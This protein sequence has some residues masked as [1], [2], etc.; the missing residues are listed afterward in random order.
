MNASL[1]RVIVFFAVIAA[2]LVVL[3]VLA[4]RSVRHAELGSD[5]VNRT[6]AIIDEFDA[7]WAG[8][9]AAD[10]GWR[11]FGMTNDARDQAATRA[12]LSDLNDH[13]EVA[14]ALTRDDAAQSREVT[15]TRHLIANRIQFIEDMLR[16]RA[17]GDIGTLQTRSAADAGTAALHEIRRAL[18]KLKADQ[19]TL[20]ADRDRDAFRRAQATRWTVWCGVAVGIVLLGGVTWL[21]RDDLAAHRRAHVVLA[22]ANRELDAKVAERTTALRAA[23]DQLESENLERAWANQALE[24][25]LHYNQI[26]INS[27][28]DLVFVVTKATN[29]SRINPAVVHLTGRQPEELINQP[30]SLVVHQ[31]P[32]SPGGSAVDPIAQ[33]MRD[34]RDLRN[35]SAMIEGRH[36]RKIPAKFTVFPLRDRDKVVGGVV[37][38][39]EA[40]SRG[41]AADRPS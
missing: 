10:G 29:I 18:E 2:L 20:L 6:Y 7:L 36:G 41:G 17:A 40:T 4:V 15:A 3:A 21:I 32:G 1:R 24:H 33:A 22:E 8:V 27:I 25:Q 12:A 34:G 13:L 28:N 11:T 19:M 38:L 31:G 9:Q 39:Q 37:V 5:W 14:T 23:N 30:L 16:L 35:E 26:I